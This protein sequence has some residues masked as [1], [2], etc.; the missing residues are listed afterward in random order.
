MQEAEYRACLPFRIAA[1][2]LCLTVFTVYLMSG[3]VAKFS[4]AASGSDSGRVARYSF[5]VSKDDSTAFTVDLS[6]LN[7]PSASETVLFK[8]TDGNCEVPQK[9]TVTVEDMGNLPLTYDLVKDG[10]SVLSTKG[11]TAEF[12]F[13]AGTPETHNYSLTV[14]WNGTQADHT[15]SSEIDFVIV[16]VK[17]EQ[18]D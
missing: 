5:D 18:I 15:L 14:T 7:V 9:Y 8:V 10:T 1:L 11:T 6:G 16:T 12:T 3:M 17:A 13:T 4:T 2:L